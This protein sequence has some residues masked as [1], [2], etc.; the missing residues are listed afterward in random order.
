[1]SMP[2]HRFPPPWTVEETDDVF[3][4]AV[5]RTWHLARR[6]A[7]HAGADCPPCVL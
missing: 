7:S 3:F 5:M 4:R 6:G 1:L 2:E